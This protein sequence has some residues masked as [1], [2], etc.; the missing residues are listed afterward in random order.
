MIKRTL[1]SFGILSTIFLLLPQ[2]SQ[3]QEKQ[4]LLHKPLKQRIAREKPLITLYYLPWC[5]YCIKVTDYL[6]QIHRAVPLKNI[7]QEVKYKEE[8]RKI[9]GKTQVPCLI[10]NGKAM[11]ES[12]AIIQWL[13]QNK[14]ILEHN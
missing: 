3:A 14:S 1:L 12:T 7:Q 11:Y 9:G 5:P 6:R 8:L 13:S 10:I 4:E 2:E